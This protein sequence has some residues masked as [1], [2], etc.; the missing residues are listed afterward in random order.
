MFLGNRASRTEWLSLSLSLPLVLL[1][2]V[3]LAV[4]G[5]DEPPAPA[6]AGGDKVAVAEARGRA[7]LLHE[8]VEAMLRVVHRDYY[9]EDE[10]LPIPSLALEAVFE[11][12][13]RSQQVELRWLA[14]NT[15]A[16]NIDHN[17]QN[18]FEK[19]AA[20]ALSS[21][22][23]EYERVEDGR[24]SR[25][26]TIVLSSQCL[27]CHLPSRMSTKDRAAGLLVSMPVQ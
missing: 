13:A 12:V 23:T 5:A 9:R 2:P 6:V 16:M 15:P 18:D 4:R 8:T 17:P 21:Q 25:V 20:K 27:K 3:A 22:D 26:A 10:K 24:Y 19:A 1:G 14:I 11:E 7:K